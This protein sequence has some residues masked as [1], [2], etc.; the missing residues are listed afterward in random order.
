MPLIVSLFR[1]HAPLCRERRHGSC[2]SLAA[3]AA[4][5]LLLRAMIAMPLL[6]S[7]FAIIAYAMAF[8]ARFDF[9]LFF[10]DAAGKGT[11]CARARAAPCA[12]A[13]ARRAPLA[14]RYTQ[15]RCCAQRLFFAV[16]DFHFSPFFFVYF[17]RRRLPF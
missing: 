13:Y 11:V 15:R 16:F 9:M 7:A 17:S 8:E 14:M 1:R 3:D 5:L 6:L 2:L 4:P 12:M 10:F